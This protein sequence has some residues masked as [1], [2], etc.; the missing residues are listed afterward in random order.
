[1]HPSQYEDILSSCLL[2]SVHDSVKPLKTACGT[3]RDGGTS[4]SDPNAA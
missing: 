2:M 4:F 3:G 1:M